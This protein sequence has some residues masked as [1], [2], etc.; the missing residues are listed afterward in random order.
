M[1]SLVSKKYDPVIFKDTTD[2]PICLDDFD[3]EAKNGND[4]VT[5]LP[6]SKHH[7]FHTTCIKQ[8]LWKQDICPLCKKQVKD[9][10]CKQLGKDFDKVYKMPQDSDKIEFVEPVK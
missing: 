7:V 4:M 3:S 2:C 9:D 8:W 10:E 5:P 1:K 6:C